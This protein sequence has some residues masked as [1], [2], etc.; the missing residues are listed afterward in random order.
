MSLL[1]V[2]WDAVER[3]IPDIRS[4]VEVELVGT[5]LTHQRFLR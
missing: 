5:P 3:V 1:K 2:L 4:R